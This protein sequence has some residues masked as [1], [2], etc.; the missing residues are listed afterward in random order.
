M[1]KPSDD[2]D[3]KNVVQAN[4]EKIP[5]YARQKYDF[6][7]ARFA[8]KFN[9]KLANSI[10][11]DIA[12][13]SNTVEDICKKHQ[14]HKSTWYAW[15]NSIPALSDAMKKARKV[16]SGIL[17]DEMLE[18]DKDTRD[19]VTEKAKEKDKVA[20]CKLLLMAE[21]INT[22]RL[23]FVIERG[24]PASFGKYV[25][26]PAT[27]INVTVN[28]NRE[29]AWQKRFNADNAE[30]TDISPDTNQGTSVQQ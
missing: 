28:D 5:C 30:Y 18:H 12:N 7:I 4:G 21:R 20:E 13:T 16:R 26:S 6:S 14:I 1:D 29:Q 10:L 19:M 8:P 24:D 22:E 25:D 17:Y 2:T 15:C 23:R 27:T 11:H 3:K 9:E